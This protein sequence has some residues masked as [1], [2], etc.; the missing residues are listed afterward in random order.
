VEHLLEFFQP[1]INENPAEINGAFGER[2][3]LVRLH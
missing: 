3:L 1:V 2:A